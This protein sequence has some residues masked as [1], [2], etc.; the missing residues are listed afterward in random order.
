MKKTIKGSKTGTQGLKN[1]IERSRIPPKLFY[2]IF[3]NIDKQ[4]GGTKKSLILIHR[5]QQ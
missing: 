2:E 5:T 4:R 1:D 3:E